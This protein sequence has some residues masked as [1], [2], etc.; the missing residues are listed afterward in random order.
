VDI[1]GVATDSSVFSS[2]GPIHKNPWHN[3]SHSWS[4]LS[5]NAVADIHVLCV[6]Q[7]Y[8]PIEVPVVAPNVVGLRGKAGNFVVV[9]SGLRNAEIDG[10]KVDNCTAYMNSE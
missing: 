3:V 1:V 10:C 8:C 4:D 2:L 5:R 6:G 7:D 9:L